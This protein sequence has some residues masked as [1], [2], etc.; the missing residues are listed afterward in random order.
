MNALPAYNAELIPDDS[1]LRVKDF[2]P[3][4]LEIKHKPTISKTTYRRYESLVRIHILPA[5]GDLKLQGV[6]FPNES[7]H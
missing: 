2:I 5:I 6:R 1:K 7:R 3:D 4:W